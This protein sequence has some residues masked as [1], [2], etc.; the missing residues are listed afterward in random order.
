VEV[1]NRLQDAYNRAVEPK[2]T[3]RH[4]LL[5]I[6]EYIA[7]FIERPEHQSVIDSIHNSQFD[8]NAERERLET[9]ARAELKKA[10]SGLWFLAQNEIE[11]TLK[12]LLSDVEKRHSTTLQSI[13]ATFQSICDANPTMSK[14]PDMPAYNAYVDYD[15]LVKRD[16]SLSVLNSWDNLV[17]HYRHFRHQED[18]KTSAGKLFSQDYNAAVQRLHTEIIAV[19][20]GKEPDRFEYLNLPELVMDLQ[21]FHAYAVDTMQKRGRVEKAEDPEGNKTE[22]TFDKISAIFTFRGETAKFQPKSGRAEVLRILTGHQ[23]LHKVWGWDEIFLALESPPNDEITSEDRT[24]Q[25]E[26]IKL[27]HKEINAH[28]AARTQCKKF[29]SYTIQ[30]AQINPDFLKK[31]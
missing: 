4:I 13:H 23:D 10:I 30:T 22:W 19:V 29:I 5:A 15:R 6:L 14:T 21:R 12:T 9:L 31:R 11:Q 24:K 7:L 25:P 16:E 2:A 28:I 27:F 18:F 3:D 8:R 26:R 17:G 1:S 20:D